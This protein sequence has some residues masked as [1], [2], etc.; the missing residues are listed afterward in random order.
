[1]SNKKIIGVL[2]IIILGLAIYIVYS[3]SKSSG[4]SIFEKQRACIEYRD[5]A[6]QE[7]TDNYSLASSYFYEVFFSPKTDTCLYTYGLVLTGISPKEVG[8]FV[9]VD[10]FTKETLFSLQYDNGGADEKKYSYNIR[11]VYEAELKKYK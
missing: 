9:I 10:Y 7:M 8:S 2:G 3:N 1:M 6:A 4:D 11:P 5:D